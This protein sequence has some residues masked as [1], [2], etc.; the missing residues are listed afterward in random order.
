MAYD[1][2]CHYKLAICY[3][4]VTM[5][6]HAIRIVD[7]SLLLVIQ[8]PFRVLEIC[9]WYPQSE[10]RSP[11]G[12]Q[13]SIRALCKAC[14]FGVA[15]PGNTAAKWRCYC[16]IHPHVLLNGKTWINVQCT[17]LCNYFKPPQVFNYIPCCFSLIKGLV[18]KSL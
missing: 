6:V 14:S 11:A 18:H 10:L 8:H 13:R 2:V 3:F 9:W 12:G 15:S 1:H 5:V 7:L 16:G 4:N 17:H